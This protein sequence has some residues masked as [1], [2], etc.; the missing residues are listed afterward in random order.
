MEL[1]GLRERFIPHQLNAQKNSTVKLEKSLK[2]LR[3]SALPTTLIG[4][5]VS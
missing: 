4:M 3:V 5:G 2:E 1:V